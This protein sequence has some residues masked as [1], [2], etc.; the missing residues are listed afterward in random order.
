MTPPPPF[1]R[2]PPPRHASHPTL[3]PRHPPRPGRLAARSPPQPQHVAGPAPTP[4]RQPSSL[5]AA[6]TRNAPPRPRFFTPRSLPVP[7][8][9]QP[10]DERTTP[11]RGSRSRSSRRSS[12]RDFCTASVSAGAHPSSTGTGLLCCAARKPSSL[13]AAATRNAPPRPRFF[14]PRSLPV[15]PGSQP[16]DERTTSRS[17]GRSRS[18]RRSGG[19]DFCTASVSAA[20]HPSSTG[21]G[22][23][24]CALPERTLMD[25]DRFFQPAN[26][27]QQTANREPRTTHTA[28]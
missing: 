2:P 10:Q 13:V 14:T 4:A 9:S 15:L 21:T 16:Q 27:G 28:P 20:A 24:C 26:R 7:P 22:L 18:S 12:G 5:V 19:R 1:H 23:L 3:H 8:A 25:R 6:A 17:G 11:R